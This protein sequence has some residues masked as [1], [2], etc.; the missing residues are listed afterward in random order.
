MKVRSVSRV[1]DNP[2]VVL[3]T[4]D[5]EPSDGD[6]RRLHEVLRANQ[7]PPYCCSCGSPR[8]VFDTQWGSGAHHALLS[9]GKCPC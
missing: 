9:G 8:C 1:A 4:L 7:L 5:V 6:L 2:K 3:V